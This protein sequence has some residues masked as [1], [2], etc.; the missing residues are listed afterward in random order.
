MGPP[1]EAEKPICRFG[2][3][4][5]TSRLANWFCFH[6]GFPR[7]KEKKHGETL[8]T[9]GMDSPRDELT[10]PGD[11]LISSFNLMV[12]IDFPLHS[13]RLTWTLDPAPSLSKRSSELPCQSEAVYLAARAWNSLPNSPERSGEDS[14]TPRPAS[15]V[16]HCQGPS[17]YLGNVTSTLPRRPLQ[18]SPG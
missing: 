3:Q 13:P 1:A 9:K 16:R 17:L 14:P 12:D 10:L 2:K 7:P 18:I 11:S 5:H 4:A 8:G 6:R 15:T